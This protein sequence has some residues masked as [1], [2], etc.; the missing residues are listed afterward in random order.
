MIEKTNVIGH[1]AA[2][3]L[4]SSPK[5]EVRKDRNGNPY[6]WCPNPNCN[7]QV[8]TQGK[9]DRAKHMLAKMT[10]I[11]AAPATTA[12]SSAVAETKPAAAA[13]SA[14]AAPSAPAADK[15]RFSILG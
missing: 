11:A 1:W 12:P 2:C 13:S 7:V 8:F 9:G 10:P 15:K 5:P 4:C 6:L 3:F 14:P